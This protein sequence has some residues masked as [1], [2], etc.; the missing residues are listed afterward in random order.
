M[1]FQP[2]YRKQFVFYKMYYAKCITQNVLRKMYYAKCITQ[3]V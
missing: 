2:F 1:L 3:N